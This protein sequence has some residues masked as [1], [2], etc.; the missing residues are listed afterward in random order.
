MDFEDD[1]T[2]GYGK[3]PVKYRFQKGVSGNPAGRPKSNP[4]LGEVVRRELN[5][6]IVV[7]ENGRRKKMTK[8][9]AMVKQAANKAVGGD[10]KSLRFLA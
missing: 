5:T 3:P 9:K 2:V 6:T 10:L 4:D 7:T 1:S 8:K